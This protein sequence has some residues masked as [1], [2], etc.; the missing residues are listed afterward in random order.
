MCIYDESEVLI[1]VVVFVV[2]V[3]AVVV[4]ALGVIHRNKYE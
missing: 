1:V 4:I 2:V 3:D